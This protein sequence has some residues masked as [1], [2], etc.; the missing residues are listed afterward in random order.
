MRY[1]APTR[2]LHALIALG[3][4]AQLLASLV[5]VTPRPGRLPNAWFEIH[6]YIGSALLLLLLAHWAWSASRHYA[7]ELGM[8]V[9]WSSRTRLADLRDDAR[10]MLR[11]ATRLRLPSADRPRPGSAAVE[12]LGLLTATCMAASGVVWILGSQPDGATGPFIHLVK[13]AHGAMGTVMWIYLLAHAGMAVLHQ[14][15]G[16][17]TLRTM[18]VPRRAGDR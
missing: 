17:G 6:Q 7:G 15:A 5:M 12:G 9:P 13:S 14:W 10:R 2:L 16:E 4:L 3:V 1:D 8:L 18:F 11:D